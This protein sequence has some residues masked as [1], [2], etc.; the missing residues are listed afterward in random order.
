MG[1][2][3]GE[4]TWG[5]GPGGGKGRGGGRRGSAGPYA[6][7]DSTG[8]ASSLS[9]MLRSLRTSSSASCKLVSV[10]RRKTQGSRCPAHNR[11]ATS[12][13]QGT[14]NHKPEPQMVPAGHI[15]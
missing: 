12:R 11:V 6:A 7:L 10:L 2:G 3:G 8:S 14:G 9:F 4:S 1:S 15:K 5:S 13:I